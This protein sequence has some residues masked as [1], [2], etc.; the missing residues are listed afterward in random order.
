[1]Q[2]LSPSTGQRADADH[3]TLIHLRSLPLVD[4]VGFALVTNVVSREERRGRYK[5]PLDMV[6]AVIKESKSNLSSTGL[7][8]AR[9]FK[10]QQDRR[11]TRVLER[12]GL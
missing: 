1:M 9:S 8:C 2:I 6:V 3:L 5:T 11:F 10:M 12:E 7:H 4:F